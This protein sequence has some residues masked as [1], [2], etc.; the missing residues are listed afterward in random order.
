MSASGGVHLEL[1]APGERTFS[2]CFLC[3]AQCSSAE[4]SVDALLDAL[5]ELAKVNV[6]DEAFEPVFSLI[7]V[8]KSTCL[9]EEAVS[10]REQLVGCVVLCVVFAEC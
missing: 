4:D 8:W 3:I 7:S 2:H 10:Q 6:S 5:C 1:L 9:I